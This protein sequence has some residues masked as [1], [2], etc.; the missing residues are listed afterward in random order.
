MIFASLPECAYKTNNLKYCSNF[1]FVFL[2]GTPI[3]QFY[4]K[5]SIFMTGGTGFL[6][7]SITTPHSIVLKISLTFSFQLLWTNF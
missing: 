5:Q 2:D 7:K 6:G 4:N 1:I 3:Q